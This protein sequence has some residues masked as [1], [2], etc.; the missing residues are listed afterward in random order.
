M[1]DTTVQECKCCG[2]EDDCIDGL[3]SSCHDFNLNHEKTHKQFLDKP[4]AEHPDVQRLIGQV[5][6]LQAELKAKDAS[7]EASR[8]LVRMKDEVI[9]AQ[10]GSL[11]TRNE[12][13]IEYGTHGRS[14][15]TTMCERDKH[16]DYPCTCGFEQALKGNSDS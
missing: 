9:T 6:E 1:S 13:L 11:K 7:L 16:S 5:V 8:K 15:D 14:S 10:A 3:C 12:A 4:V 2:F